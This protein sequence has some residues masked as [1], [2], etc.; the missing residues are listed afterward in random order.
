MFYNMVYQLRSM[1]M[2]VIESPVK[3]ECR[4]RS[5]YSIFKKIIFIICF[6]FYEYFIFLFVLVLNLTD[7][8]IF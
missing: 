5:G 4:N 1:R 8:R 3:C 2:Q 6:D 7:I